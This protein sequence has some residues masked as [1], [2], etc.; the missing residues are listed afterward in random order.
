MGVTFIELNKNEYNLD[1]INSIFFLFHLNSPNSIYENKLKKNYVKR[2]CIF[3]HLTKLRIKILLYFNER[4]LLN[5]YK[6]CIEA[7]TRFK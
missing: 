7:C 5:W 6:I 1:Y 3:Y 2:K 4:K